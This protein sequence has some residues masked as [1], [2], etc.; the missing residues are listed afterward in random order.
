MLSYTDRIWTSD[1]NDAIDRLRIQKGFSLFF[2][3]EIMSSHVGPRECH[4][5]GRSISM[6]TRTGVVLFG[7]MGV[8]TNLL[9]MDDADKTELAAAVALHNKHRR[10]I[11]SG[12]LVRLDTHSYDNSFGIIG[13]NQQQTLFYYAL[14]DSQPSSALERLRLR[15]LNATTRYTVNIVWPLELSRDSKFILDV[16]DRAFISGDILVNVGIQL[17]LCC[18]KPFLFFICRAKANPL[19][20]IAEYQTIR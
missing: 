7:N 4:I 3:A 5:T 11:H 10:L 1:S 13:C 17:R 12:K 8:E 6:A 14:L 9:D 20:S 19:S 18:R 16:I 15:G 2:P